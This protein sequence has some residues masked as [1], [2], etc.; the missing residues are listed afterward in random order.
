VN[1]VFCSPLWFDKQKS[2]T[3]PTKHN[4]I[5]YYAKYFILCIPLLLNA[6]SLAYKSTGDIMLGYAEDQGIPYMLATDDVALG[7][8]M[9]EAFTPFLLSFSQV[10]TSPD[11]LAILFYLM[12]GNCSEFKA[13]DEELRY[14]RATHAKNTAEAQD[15]RIAQKRLLHQAAHRQ[16]TGYHYLTLAIAEPGEQCPDFASDSEEFY[17]LIGLV[18]GIQA[19]MNDI[20]SGGSTAVPMGIAAKVGRGAVCLDNEKWWGVPDSIQAAIQA[21]M[22]GSQQ[23]ASEP[24]QKMEQSI[25]IG[26]QQGM[27]MAQV[28]AAQV[29]LGLGNTE[30]VK[31]I[32]REFATSKT[33]STENETYKILNKISI[34]QIRAISDRLWTEATGKRTPMGKLGTFWDDPK[35]PIET[36][37]IE[38]IL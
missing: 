21:T 1:S 33:L 35:K 4:K 23:G 32:I 19:I 13:W 8:A 10:T 5:N 20:A 36:I 14:L 24:L 6:C 7:C 17:W 22:P 29:D 16:L 9:S 25:Q 12:A 28:L 37:D 3:Y 38:A 30:Q 2:F 15:A 31:K 26:L 27:H 34:L 11:H 18:N